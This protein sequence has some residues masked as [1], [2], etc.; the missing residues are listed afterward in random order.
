MI[1]PLIIPANPCPLPNVIVA[2]V[3]VDDTVVILF[4]NPKVVANLSTV[5][6]VTDFFKSFVTVSPIGERFEKVF[7][8]GGL[9]SKLSLSSCG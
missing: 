8:D 4:A 3:D 2:D 5:S 1:V 9:S 6:L 7:A